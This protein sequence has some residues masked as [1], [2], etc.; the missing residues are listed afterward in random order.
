MWIAKPIAQLSENEQIQWEKISERPLSQTLAW[1]RAI[2][3]VSG[4]A[5]LVFSPEEKVGGIIFGM[6]VTS[7]SNDERIRFEC[8][9]GPLLN[10]DNSEM[11]PRQLATFALATSKLEPN[12]H[13]LSLRP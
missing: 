6:P 2:N 7:N 3:A 4:K 11:A 10:W 5:Y 8:I 9:N 12:F 13:S 1:A